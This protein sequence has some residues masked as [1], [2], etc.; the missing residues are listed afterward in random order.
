MYIFMMINDFLCVHLLAKTYIHVLLYFM[1]IK[2]KLYIRNL[3]YWTFVCISEGQ[4]VIFISTYG[5]QP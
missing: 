3:Y 4:A 5:I 2:S 1:Q